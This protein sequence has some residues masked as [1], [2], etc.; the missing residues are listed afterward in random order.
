MLFN[1]KKSDIS[2]DLELENC[3]LLHV[4]CTKFLGVWIDE[5]LNW[6]RHLNKLLLII[7]RNRYLLHCGKKSLSL[8]ACKLV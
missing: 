6:E 8:H 3:I 2:F 1:G 7:K 5:R 4:T